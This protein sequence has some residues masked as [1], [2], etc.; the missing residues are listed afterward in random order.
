MYE[1]FL[2]VPI[3]FTGNPLYILKNNRDK[4]LAD[5]RRTLVE[6]FSTMI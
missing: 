3:F 4:K 6:T 2:N 5:L 1:S